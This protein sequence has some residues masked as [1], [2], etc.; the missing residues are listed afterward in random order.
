MYDLVCVGETLIDFVTTTGG[1]TIEQADTFTAHL[2]GSPA[3]VAVTAAR[4]GGSVAMVSSVGDDPLAVRARAVLD[5]AGVV[6]RLCVDLDHAT[7]AVVVVRS[8]D[9]PSFAVLRGADRYL[10]GFPEDLFS[11]RWIHTSAF[12]LSHDPQRSVI[13]QVLERAASAGI[14]TSLD[15]NF[16]RHVWREEPIQVLADLLAHVDL[17]KASADD[18]DRLFGPGDAD[19]YLSRLAEWGARAILLTQGSGPVM[20][21][22]N[23]EKHEMAVP[24]RPVTD[25]TGAGDAFMGGFILAKLDGLGT[26]VAVAVG[27]EAAGK[28]VEVLGHVP[29]FPDRQALYDLAR[30]RV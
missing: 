20:Y 2:G 15:V 22:G 14:G 28:S 19:F 5:R 10:R 16:H 24:P 4:L 13:S 9:T 1:V 17:V 11:T 3:N 30:L 29:G 6:D 26:D 23:G 21:V 12:A 25:V 18:C 8:H 27:I 7:T